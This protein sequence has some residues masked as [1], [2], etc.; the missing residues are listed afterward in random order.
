MGDRGMLTRILA[1]KFG[2]FLTF[3]ALSPEFQSASGQ[4]TVHDMRDIYRVYDIRPETKVYGI[5]G[6]P[7][8]HS[9]SPVFHNASFKEAG[10]N[11][12]LKKGLDWI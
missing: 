3:V 12:F 1:P 8:A 6:N 10:S 9:K 11:P 4:S 5:V 7:V 2:G